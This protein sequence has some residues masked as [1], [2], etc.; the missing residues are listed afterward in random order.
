MR[1]RTRPQPHAPTDLVVRARSGAL[2]GG[3]RKDVRT[4][5]AQM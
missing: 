3:P 2:L 4:D 1:A 5:D